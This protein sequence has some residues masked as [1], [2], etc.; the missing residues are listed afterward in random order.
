M[1]KGKQHDAEGKACS[2]FLH[3]NNTITSQYKN[4]PKSIL[5]ILVHFASEKS[6]LIK[7]KVHRIS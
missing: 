5:I 6:N 3:P 4:I 7:V 2:Q 1:L